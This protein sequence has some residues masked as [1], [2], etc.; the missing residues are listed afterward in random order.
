M[1]RLMSY[2]PTNLN[3]WPVLTRYPQNR[4]RKIALPLGGIGTGTVSLGGRGNLTDWE[5]MNRPAKGFVPRNTFFALYAK[6]QGEAAV[7]RVLEGP[8]EDVD[9]DGPYGCK[10]PNHGL[11]RFRQ[12]SFEAAYPFGK[13]V[14]DDDSV[15]VSVRLGG[16]N[17]LI[18]GHADDSGIPAAVL[19]I[20]LT[21]KTGKT[22]E[23]S[24]CGCLENFIGHDGRYGQAKHNVNEFRQDRI[25]GIYMYS[26][27]VDPVSEQFGTMS[28]T[29]TEEDVTYSLGWRGWEIKHSWSERLINFW[30]DFSSDGRLDAYS[31]DNENTP[32]ASLA[33]SVVLPPYG[34]KTVTYMICWHFPNRQSW[35]VLI[36]PKVEQNNTKCC[37]GGV[38]TC[39]RPVRVGNYYT[40][41]YA[42]AW[43]VAVKTA[44]R[45]DELEQASL[46]FV[47]AF[48]SGD[49]PD[50][51]KEAAL[52]NVST[53]RSQTCFRTDEGTFFGWEGCGVFHGSCHGNATHVWNYDLASGFLFGELASGMR[54]AEFRFG[55]T[56]KGL[57]NHRLMLPLYRGTEFGVAAADGQTG[58]L[59]R[60]YREWKLSGDDAFLTRL[61]PNAR[62]AIEFCWQ[63]GGWDADQDGVAEGC[64]HVTYDVEFFGPNPLAG[65]WY[66]GAL[67]AVEEMAA[68]L[69]ERDLAEKCRRLFENGSRY[70]D[71]RLFN[72]EYYEQEVRGFDPELIA[73]GLQTGE[74]AINRQEPELQ[75][76]HGCLTDQLVGQYMAHALGLGYLLNPGHI[77]KALQSIVKYNH[78]P[79]TDG[80]FNPMRSFVLNDEPSL[81]V[82][83]YPRGE[84]PKFPFPYFSEVMNGMEY[85]AA[86][87]MLYEGLTDEGVGLIADIR[88]RYEGRKRN[89]FNEQECGDHYVRSMA[90]WGAV[91][92]LTG[93]QFSAVDRTMAFKAA[94]REAT[95]FWSNGYAYGIV[96]QRPVQ[97]AVEVE[98]SV[99]Q[100]SVRLSRFGLNGW[101]HVQF[102]REKEIKKGEILKIAVG[103]E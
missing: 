48:L 1:N 55:V 12:C 23:A 31:G 103:R 33:A 89:P 28:L 93:F 14:L 17:P 21:N 42:N 58:T 18:P 82:C 99:L 59:M 19:K 11:P 98:L 92:A 9:Y 10:V 16:F 50:A 41:A 74:G 27:G 34:T 4:L 87:H 97:G 25:Q 46:Q 83:T 37:G 85:A 91:L 84:R 24:V 102:E 73:P 38:C 2:D 76:T 54:E 22:V 30:D 45:L 86:A 96:K 36:K 5:I 32:A 43:D 68:H 88:S 47:N 52:Y 44:S 78:R 49:L 56:E 51:V 63:E 101:G 26:L 71:E 60:L 20:E 72:G 65:V 53:L 80:F 79:G 66:L 6:P 29:T 15:P 61:W 40:T 95:Y 39:E 81:V 64:Q 7:T 94:S 70:I 75:L 8:I 67:R 100:G 90:S 62:K 77:R 13:A 35:D 69:G 3:H 57:L